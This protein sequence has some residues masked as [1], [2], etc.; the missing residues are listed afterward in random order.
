MSAQLLVGAKLS[1]STGKVVL[2]QIRSP[3]QGARLTAGE[4]ERV[5]T[6]ARVRCPRGPQAEPA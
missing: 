3:L 2:D 4:L 5:G 6:A 1:R